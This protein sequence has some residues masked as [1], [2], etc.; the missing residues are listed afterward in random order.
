MDD[1]ARLSQG[2][3]IT[4]RGN[5]VSVAAHSTAGC[6][7]ERHLAPARASWREILGIISKAAVALDYAHAIG[8]IHGTLESRDIVI[9]DNGDSVECRFRTAGEIKL[10]SYTAPEQ[11]AAGSADCLTDLYRLGV[12]F[13]KLLSGR[14][15]FRA[16]DINALC[17]QIRDDAPQPPRQLVHGLPQD[18]DSICLRLLAKNPTDRIPS[19]RQLAKDLQV[20]LN[21]FD[22][23]LEP[24]SRSTKGTEEDRR[25]FVILHFE[26]VTPLGGDS[27]LEAFE[28]ANHA[29]SG[30]VQKLLDQSNAILV[31]WDGDEILLQLKQTFSQ[32]DAIR[33]AVV[34]G[35]GLLDIAYRQTQK[36]F[37]HYVVRVESAELD[38]SSSTV[39]SATDRVRSSELVR[40][41][42]RVVG[43]VSRER[44]QVDDGTWRS[45]RRWVE[46]TEDCAEDAEDCTEDAHGKRVAAMR[47][48]ADSER[49]RLH[50]LPAGPQG[51]TFGPASSLA[52]VKARW[53]QATEGLGQMV[54][55][56]GEEG[57]GKSRLITEVVRS[58]KQAQ[59]P[60][61]VV[62]TCMPARQERNF[63]PLARSLK[64]QLARLEPIDDAR[65]TVGNQYLSDIG[66]T[67]SESVK[68][69]S[70]ILEAE[71]M[72]L[73][74]Q[75][76][77][78]SLP[79]K[80]GVY[81]LIL[82][83][84]GRTT[85]KSP[86]LFV[87]EDLQW[88]DPA[89]LEL[90]RILATD[91]LYEHLLLIC[92]FRPEFETLWGS[93]AHQTQVALRRLSEKHVKTMIGSRLA[94]DLVGEQVVEQVMHTT[95][96][97]PLYIEAYLNR[98]G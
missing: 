86:L 96:G 4:V 79:E 39:D 46:H 14:E 76:R 72:A 9:H 67:S 55:I 11:L 31:H 7:V 60:K 41:V 28:V 61:V 33:R 98:L 16:A 74:D 93:R 87:V 91:R 44:V 81:D 84:I 40:R 36:S 92:T 53:T 65:P 49:L 56:I 1:Q 13:Y 70:S 30:G 77:P 51:P 58:V 59:Q 89:T 17:E 95:G 22:G 6:P 88:A 63:H 8:Q 73:S 21:R 71:N 29:T 37:E 62:W 97:V 52:I 43:E 32:D 50:I 26:T 38:R 19:G 54:L 27:S 68:L 48:S 75:S 15:P 85:R 25:D 57:T 64:Q 10:S 34:I 24:K 42:P 12:V 35:A 5:E 90:V 78:L 83:W 94:D 47:A 18:I 23:Q 45:L 69:L 66:E 80:E 20:I 3:S 82:R 2:I